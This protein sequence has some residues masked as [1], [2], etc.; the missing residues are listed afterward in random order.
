MAFDSLRNL[1]RVC[2]LSECLVLDSE[3]VI[4]G[5]VG[6]AC[7]K[8]DVFRYGFCGGRACDGSRE[9]YGAGAKNLR[10]R[11]G[12]ALAVFFVPEGLQIMSH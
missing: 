11:E 9:G 10:K 2:Q 1:G 4:S 6:C 12:P 3:W 8:T 7:R 5:R